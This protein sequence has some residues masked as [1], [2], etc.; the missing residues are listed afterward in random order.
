MQELSQY[1]IFE[2]PILTFQSWREAA[3]QTEENANAFSL[4]TATADGIPSNRY[5][6]LKGL[7]E[8]KFFFFSNYLSLKAKCISENPKAEMAFYWHKEQ[9]QVRV[10]GAVEKTPREF[11]EKYFASR[12]EDSKYASFCSI[13]SAPIADKAALLDKYNR[14]RSEFPDGVE[15]PDNWGGYYL[16]PQ[17]IEF[18][19]YGEHRL[20]DRF[21]FEREGEEWKVQR[22]QP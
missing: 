1:G 3:L 7:D 4:A 6:L 9:K 2:D 20:N 17:K 18:F 15:C 8:G 11:S 19:I 13:Q 16:T 12:G 21:V 10:F 5:L 22:V 14:A